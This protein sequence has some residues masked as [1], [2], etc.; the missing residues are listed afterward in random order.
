MD[1]GLWWALNL[2]ILLEQMLVLYLELGSQWEQNLVQGLRLAQSLV[3]LLEFHLAN[4]LDMG[5][6]LDYHW[7]R[8]LEWRWVLPWVLPT[9]TN[10]R[11]PSWT[12]GGRRPTPTSSDRGGA[13]PF[14]SI[15]A[16]DQVARSRRVMSSMRSNS[17]PSTS[18]TWS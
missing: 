3:Q 9:P 15:S 5:S 14:S 7:G 8:L 12:S 10:S 18:T 11:R 17:D 16:K 6:Q 13:R 1:R 2:V 4:H